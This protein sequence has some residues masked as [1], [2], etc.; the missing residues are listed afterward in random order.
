M[1]NKLE[2]DH[3]KMIWSTSAII[4]CQAVKN[5]F[6]KS[7]PVFGN[8]SEYGF[9][10][11][12]ANIS[13]NQEDF[14]SI[15]N[16]IENIVIS[17]TEINYI[18]KNRDEV[19]EHLINNYR[20]PTIDSL[21][22]ITMFHNGNFVD[23][24]TQEGTKDISDLRF[25]KILSTSSTY[26]MGDKNN[27]S[28]IRIHGIAFSTKKQLD[29]HMRFLEEVKKRDHREI[30]KKQELFMFSDIAPGFPFILPNGMHILNAL[31]LFWKE[32][33]DKYGYIE[34]STPA[35]CCLDL[36]KKSGHTDHYSDNM[37]HICSSSTK[38]PMALK[39]MNCPA[40]MIYFGS[41][42]VSH[43]DLP[44]RI[45][46]KGSVFRNELSGSLSGLCRVRNFHQDDAH[47]FVN[48]EQL[49]TELSSI[50]DLIDEVYSM[51]NLEY[52]V[53]LAT[54]PEKSCGSDKE[55]DK[56]IDI[57][58]NVIENRHGFVTVNEGDGAFYGPKI[59]IYIK[60]AIGRTWQC[61]TVQLDFGIS[62]RFDLSF[63]N[64]E[65]S[66]EKPIVIHR[67]IFG[68]FER[69]MAILIE[70]FAGRFPMWMSPNSIAIIPV[71]ES[72][73]DI[74]NDIRK[75]ILSSSGCRADIISNDSGLNK[76]IKISTDRNYNYILVVGDKETDK[77][78]INIR[79]RG[80][81]YSKN[82]SYLEFLSKIS[83][84]IKTR[85]SMSSI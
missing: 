56:S 26:W 84:E 70:H 7:I 4:L 81:K 38:E 76:N 48:Q 39:A 57:L 69:F 23:I 33:H 9:Y 61:G 80:Q 29:G 3:Q 32:I 28:L 5:L 77:K 54:R 20:K 36:W 43:K 35:I 51:L 58:K 2:K 30:G 11:D 83:L 68:S 82:M 65:N 55:W 67:A 75:D 59:D 78:T 60:D 53:E 74:A 66:L 44:L 49:M 52:K 50:L 15:E 45:S 14:K 13:I 22:G 24:S 71:S 47:I 27:D 85:S 16:E 18:P 8:T 25:F 17:S 19:P 10:Y 12:F 72:N 79:V 64:K 73:L 42:Q 41:R 37:F 34:I 46:E 63:N 6:P 40:T 21:T 31:T 1:N 62:D